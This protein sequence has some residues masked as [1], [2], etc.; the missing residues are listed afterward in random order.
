MSDSG[1]IPELQYTHPDGTRRTRFEMDQWLRQEVPKVHW[2]RIHASKTFALAKNISWDMRE[3]VLRHWLLDEM[4]RRNLIIGECIGVNT[5]ASNDETELR[6]FSQRLSAAI[7]N[8]S[9]VQPQ[10]AEGIDMTTTFTPPPPPVGGIPTQPSYPAGPPAP[11]VPPG[12]P[13]VPMGP[14]GYQPPAAPSVAPYQPPMGPPGYTPPGVPNSPPPSAPP[15]VAPP[16]GPGRKGRKAAEATATSSAPP[17]A[18]VPPVGPPPGLPQPPGFAPVGGLVTMPPVPDLRGATGTPAATAAMAGAQTVTLH[19]P[20]TL[21]SPTIDLTDVLTKLDQTLNISNSTAARFS[22]FERKLE[23]L[24][25]MVTILGRAMYQKS[26][27]T[28]IVAFLKELG[29]SIPQ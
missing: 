1:S 26:G 8:G 24:S 10:H 3:I 14:P 6:Q 27:N 5:T 21:H 19:A 17:A 7:Q 12:P 28:D 22:V 15:A 20:A 9:A 13:G 18:P 25:M 16:P 4:V 23:L 2:L 11:P 29:V